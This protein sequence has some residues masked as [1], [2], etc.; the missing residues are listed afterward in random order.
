MGPFQDKSSFFF[1]IVS[2]IVCICNNNKINNID[3]FTVSIPT[4]TLQE[5]LV[6]LAF[7][8]AAYLILVMKILP[9]YMKNREPF[10]LKNLMLAYNA[11]Q[12][13]F[14][15]YVVFIV[16]GSC[17]LYCFCRRFAFKVVACIIFVGAF[18][19]NLACRWVVRFGDINL[20]YWTLCFY[21]EIKPVLVRFWSWLIY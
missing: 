6:G 18:I 3:L 4:W 5:T 8:L 20:L 17:C 21:I 7:V 2:K 13:A 1:T 12:V 11:F 10:Q 14:S 15:I 16:S 19:F 9:S